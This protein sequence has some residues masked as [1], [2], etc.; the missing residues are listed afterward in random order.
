MSKTR[1]VRTRAAPRARAERLAAAIKALPTPLDREVGPPR[2]PVLAVA[3][4]DVLRLTIARDALPR[5]LAETARD[6]T[7]GH[8]YARFEAHR[9][10]L[11]RAVAAHALAPLEPASKATDA[12][13]PRYLAMLDV[14]VALSDVI[15]SGVIVLASRPVSYDRAL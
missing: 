6:A 9:A 10:A 3:A 15:A 1:R 5:L 11:G 8:G 7:L 4:H 13:S 14:F 12:P 2:D